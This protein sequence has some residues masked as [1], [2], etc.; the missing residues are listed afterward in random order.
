MAACTFVYLVQEETVLALPRE[1]LVMSR[2]NSRS[3]S[4]SLA[5]GLQKNKE[6]R[7]AAVLVAWQ[8]HRER[9]NGRRFLDEEVQVLVGRWS[10]RVEVGQEG[11]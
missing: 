10:M 3:R 7:D 9:D 5:G 1:S 8:R 2:L 6:E 4:R 11:A